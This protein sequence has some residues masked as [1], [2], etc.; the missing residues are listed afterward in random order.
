M[1]DTLVALV[2]G[3]DTAT[4]IPLEV[5]VIIT[6]RALLA[7]D[8]TPALIPGYGPVP[9][10]WARHLLT[11]DDLEDPTTEDLP[12]DDHPDDLDNLDDEVD[13]L[14]DVGGDDL[15]QCDRDDAADLDD[16]PDTAGPARSGPPD[17]PPGREPPPHAPT[18]TPRVPPPRQSRRAQTWLRRLYTHPATGTLVQMDSRRR[19]FDT[20]L[21]RYL[22]TRDGTCRTPWCNAPIRHLDHI[23]RWA[24][25]GPTSAENGQGLCVRCN[26][27]KDLPGFHA[28]VLHPGPQATDGHSLGADHD[29]RHSDDASTPHTVQLTT[30]TG[31]SYT[32]TA[33]PV[34]PG[35]EHH[36]THHPAT[37]HLDRRPV[38]IDLRTRAES[39]FEYH[40]AHLAS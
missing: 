20:A 25:D 34:L 18:C 24:D 30:P 4:D 3:Q 23:Q 9:A 17:G 15:G 22:I 8:D 32:S 27:V 21:R 14:D 11:P 16:S 5:Q 19:L 36:N 37:D 38:I 39:P 7:G 33:P 1:A 31:H 12:D 40:C 2:T 26:L 6:D 10:A 35:L 29:P 13:D 28:E